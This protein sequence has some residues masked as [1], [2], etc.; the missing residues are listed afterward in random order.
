MN[1]PS[2]RKLRGVGKNV[3]ILFGIAVI[4]ISGVAVGQGRISFG[5]SSLNA[6]A[7]NKSLAA[8]LDYSS[9]EEVYDELRENYDGALDQSKLLDGLKKGLVEASGDPYTEYFNEAA[10]EDFNNQLTGSF[11]GI[12]AELG[13]E[14]GNIVIIAPIAGYPAEKAGLKAK[15]IIAEINGEATTK[16]TVSDAVTKIRGEAGTKVKLTIVRANQP[17]SFE[18]TR[19]NI[20]VPSVKSDI[21]DGNIGYVQ[22]SRFGEDTVALAQKAAQNFKDKSVAGIVL[23]MRGN[24]GGLLDAAVG[25]SSLW[26]P[27]GAV[28]LQEKRDGTVVRTYKATGDP[29]LKG[30][31]TVAL[32]DEG[33][34]SA[35]EITAGALKDNGAAE[36]VGQKSYGKGSVQN[37]LKLGGSSLLGTS[38]SEKEGM[39]KVTIARWYT[40]KGKNI[41]KEGITPDT[42][43]EITADDLSAGRDPQKNK[44]LEIVRG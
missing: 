28:V 42:L 11:S 43:I 10:A 38:T 19:E 31:K 34:A 4:F 24:P 44:A 1:E 29:L 32:I 15:D 36:L 9:V 30:I 23:D 37:L 14:N 2:V 16:L 13:K 25:V 22:I 7:G 21:L 20:S 8:N 5:N 3:G 35:S 33:S 41:D 12:G 17:L 27:E 26:L 18:I 6:V 39:L 40:P